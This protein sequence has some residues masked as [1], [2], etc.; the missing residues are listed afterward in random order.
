MLCY[1]LRIKNG[2]F[3]SIQLNFKRVIRIFRLIFE[4]IKSKHQNNHFPFTTPTFAGLKTLSP[5]TYP[6]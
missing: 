3:K 2:L 4:L 6:S 1:T 5:I